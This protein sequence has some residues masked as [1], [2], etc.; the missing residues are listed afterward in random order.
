[1]RF[2]QYVKC[3]SMLLVPPPFPLSLLIRG[4]GKRSVNPSGLGVQ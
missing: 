3:Y 2:L 4:G 1:M